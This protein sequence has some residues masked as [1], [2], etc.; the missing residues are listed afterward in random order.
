[1][2]HNFDALFLPLLLL[3]IFVTP[4]VAAIV[5]PSGQ[6]FYFIFYYIILIFLQYP[7]GVLLQRLS[8]A[9]SAQLGTECGHSTEMLANGREHPWAVS[10]MTKAG[11]PSLT[12]INGIEEVQAVQGRNKL[13]GTIISPF[14]ILTVAHGF[15]RF[16]NRG[17][18][19]C[20]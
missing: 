2:V 17:A 12:C 4:P 3:A 14:H 18:G 13:G 10:I 7:A 1:M 9:E 20:E 6:Y 15:L 8:P 5:F 19:P 11:Q 16:D